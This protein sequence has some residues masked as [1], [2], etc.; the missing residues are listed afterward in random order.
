[1]RFALERGRP[2]R[3]VLLVAGAVWVWM[4]GE[5]LFAQRLTCCAE[6]PSAL[7]ELGGWV[8]MIVAMMLPSMELSLE[9]VVRRS[10]RRRRWR[11]VL[12]WVLGYVSWWVL[13]GVVFVALRQYPLAQHPHVPAALCVVS[14]AWAFLPAREH[15]HRVC[16]KTIPMRPTGMGADVDAFQQGSVNGSACV[17]MCWPLMLACAASNHNVFLMVCGALLAFHEKRAFHLSPW[18]L[19]IGSLLLAPITLIA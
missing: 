9:D 10:Y 7:V 13:L 15:W 4:L 16:H 19:A 1:M 12:G 17:A 2:E 5:A 3:V 11:A 18:P 6:R 8:G 14:A